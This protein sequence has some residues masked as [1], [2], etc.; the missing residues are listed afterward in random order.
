MDYTKSVYIPEIAL[1]HTKD[2]QENVSRSEFARR[3]GVVEN[4]EEAVIV[5]MMK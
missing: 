1:D 2:F 4:Q 5:T 3:A